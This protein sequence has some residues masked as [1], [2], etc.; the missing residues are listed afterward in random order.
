MALISRYH[1]KQ[2]TYLSGYFMQPHVFSSG[3]AL[4][5]VDEIFSAVG[6]SGGARDI[7]YS[8]KYVLRYL[9][10]VSSSSILNST[11]SHLY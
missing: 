1:T 3:E 9:S 4:S 11:L 8:K 2:S 7:S 10:H 6:A 5:W